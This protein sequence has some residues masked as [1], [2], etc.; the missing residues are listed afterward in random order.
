VRI[1]L[2]V[3]DEYLERFI[4]SALMTLGFRRHEIRVRPYPVGRNAKQW[5]TQEY[6]SEVH[7]YR[8]EANHQ[9]VALLVG[10]EAD[11]QTVLERLA[12]L[13]G[14][15]TAV[16]SNRRQNHERIAL[17]IPKWH[18]ETWLLSL[19]GQNVDEETSYKNALR[20]PDVAAAGKAFVDLLRKF[21]QDPTTNVL[22]SMKAAF[23]ESTR[24]GI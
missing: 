20:D 10:T 18:I 23:Q 17:W 8:R 5:V 12:S 4:R 22:P 16:G 24:L 15:L 21:R 7:A 1:V 11:E 14:A 3:E 2:L 19:L 6:P 13:D 9:Q